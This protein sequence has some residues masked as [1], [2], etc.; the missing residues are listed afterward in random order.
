[1]KS[2]HLYAL[3][4]F[5]INVVD[6]AT[7]LYGASLGGQEKNPLM[8]IL[9]DA[10]PWLFFAF[11]FTV[12]CLISGLILI[13]GSYVKKIRPEYKYL[14]KTRTLFHAGALAPIFIIGVTVLNNFLWI[15]AH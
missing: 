14:R 10:S 9:I 12:T 3:L 5:I 7:T 1:M 2:K 11:K 8:L 13:A 4:F 6:I 15:L